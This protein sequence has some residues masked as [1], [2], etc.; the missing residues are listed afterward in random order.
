MLS[1][2]HLKALASMG[3][4]C[5][6]GYVELSELTSKVFLAVLLI[7]FK[8]FNLGIRRLIHRIVSC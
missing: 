5:G 3:I 1:E 7:R 4:N 8:L 6:P 2:E